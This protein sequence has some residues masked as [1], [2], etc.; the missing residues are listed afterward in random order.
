M[1][2]CKICDKNYKQITN[3]HLK[4]HHVT[5]SEYL[6]LFPDEKDAIHN[7]GTIKLGQKP[8]NNGLTKETSEKVRFYFS[9]NKMG[10]KNGMYKKTHTAEARKSMGEKR[11]GSGNGM[12]GISLLTKWVTNLGEIEGRKKWEEYSER[13]STFLKSTKNTRPNKKLKSILQEM[14]IKLIEEFRIVDENDKNRYYDFY[15]PDYNIL[16]EVDGIYW[17]NYPHGTENDKHKN[18]LAERNGYRLIRIWENKL[19]SEWRLI[20]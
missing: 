10:P 2:T 11:Q 5:T 3:T 9:E 1:Y 4:K 20:I 15:L 18:K 13:K 12:Y 6:K 17:H 8:W 14:N 7:S 19:D 16:I